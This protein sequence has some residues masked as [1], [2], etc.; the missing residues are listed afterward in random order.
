VEAGEEIT[1]SRNGRPV[2]RLVPLASA[3]PQ[4]VPGVWRSKVTIADDFDEFTDADA[5][6]WYSA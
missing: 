3:R 1:L 5:A 4:R 2:A 6:E